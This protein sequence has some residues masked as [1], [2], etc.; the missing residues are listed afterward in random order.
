[1]HRSAADGDLTRQGGLGA[2]RYEGKSGGRRFRGAEAE[3]TGASGQCDL[4]GI[5]AAAGGEAVGGDAVI[6]GEFL[7]I[8]RI[9]TLAL[10]LGC[11][12]NSANALTETIECRMK[13][14]IVCNENEC[15]RKPTA[16][17]VRLIWTFVTEM[18]VS[19]INS[20]TAAYCPN[21]DVSNDKCEM[22]NIVWLDDGPIRTTF[23]PRRKAGVTQSGPEILS[24]DRLSN[25]KRLWITHPLLG[26]VGS[27]WGLCLKSPH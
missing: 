7:R 15:E 14:V 20:Y 16:K 24:F 18:G 4:E 3:C 9:C 5:D 13:E 10:L 22:F 26:G 23:L 21:A 1:V 27:I 12:A 25:P 17:T 8:I 11:T 6:N 2:G 19:K